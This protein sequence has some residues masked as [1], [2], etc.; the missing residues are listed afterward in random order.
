MIGFIVL[1]LVN[2]MLSC[3]MKESALA[4]EESS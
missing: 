2:V 1:A 3:L 4:R